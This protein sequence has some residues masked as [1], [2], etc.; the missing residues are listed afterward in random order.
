[1]AELLDARQRAMLAEMG[2]FVWE[3]APVPDTPVVPTQTTQK[4]EPAPGQAP[5]PAAS[6]VTA[7]APSRSPSE[8]GKAQAPMAPIAVADWAEVSD[9]NA[10]QLEAAARQCQDCGLCTERQTTIWGQ[11]YGGNTGRGQPSR[12]T[13]LVITDPPDE[14]D[15]ATGLP[16]GGEQS[17]AGSLLQ[18]ML[19]ATG[20]ISNDPALGVFV[21]PVTKCK[22]P[23]G[24]KLTSHE[25]MACRRYLTAQIQ[26]LA[27]QL[28][29]TLGRVAAQTMLAPVQDKAQ[30][31]GQLRGTVHEVQG[32]PLV[33]SLAPHY[34]LRNP[35]EKAKAWEDLCLALSHLSPPP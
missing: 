28:I 15:E 2:V 21:T 30:A 12:A 6:R 26:L 1:M 16:L 3:R 10:E 9:L 24:Y 29:L 14:A 19:G 33:A 20:W 13:V 34:L 17:A 7:T 27:P 22:V 18:A 25:L 8:N 4:S 31:L 35:L 11:W 5:T 23:V 32:R